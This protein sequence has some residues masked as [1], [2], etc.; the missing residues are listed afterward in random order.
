M[1]EELLPFNSY[2]REETIGILRERAKYAFVEGVFDEDAFMVAANRSY[3]LNDVRSG[4]Y[5]LKEAGNAAE[6]ESSKKITVEHVKKAIQKLE[7]FTIKKKEELDDDTRFVMGVIKKNPGRKIGELFEIYQKEGGQGAYKTFQRRIA[8]LAE[9]K[10]INVK[11]V[12]GAEG[13][14]TI[15]TSAGSVKTLD[16]F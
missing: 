7:E 8:K 11:K 9:N 15:V 16:E 3:E 5:L 12:T 2:N 10:F 1:K 6:D 4:L 13:N 14:T